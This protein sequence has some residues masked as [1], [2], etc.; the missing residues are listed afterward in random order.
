MRPVKAH[1]V[2][3]EKPTLRGGVRPGTA[4]PNVCSCFKTV[5][6]CFMTLRP[7]FMTVCSCS[8][9][10]CA[11][12]AHAIEIS[13]VSWYVL[14][15]LHDCVLLFYDCVL[16]LQML[17]SRR[18]TVRCYVSVTFDCD[19][20][21]TPSGTASQHNDCVFLLHDCV[22][23]LHGCVLLQRVDWCRKRKPLRNP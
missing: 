15:L 14:L 23:L 22:L 17:R 1:G 18:T 20:T 3:M 11:P 16:L 12:L 7:C 21:K 6:S 13:T 19:A 4:R 8:A 2:A 5:C 10:S 9:T